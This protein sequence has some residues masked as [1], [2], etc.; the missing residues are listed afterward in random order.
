MTNELLLLIG[1]LALASGAAIAAVLILRPVLRNRLGAAHAYAAWLAVPATMAA[2]LLPPLAIA[3][4]QLAAVFIGLGGA[5][6][7]PAAGAAA[8]SGAR[9]QWL[10]LAWA[11]GTGLM[12]GHFFSSHWH[13]VRSLG[14][15]A[16][17][18][19]AWVAEHDGAGPLLLGLW[20]QRVVL[21]RD[22]AARFSVDE[23][24]LILAHERFHAA[25]GDPAANALLAVLQCCFWFNPLVHIAAPR[26]R[27][28]QE[29]A[30]DA[31]VMAAHPGTARAYASA[32]M[33]SQLDDVTLSASCHWQSHHPLKE[34]I[35]QLQHSPLAPSRRLAARLAI[36]LL[37]LAGAGAALIARAESAA[38]P[39]AAGAR[40]DIGMTLTALGTVSHPRLLVREGEIFRVSKGNDGEQWDGE[41]LLRAHPTGK[42]LIKSK[43]TL[44]GKPM[45]EQSMLMDEGTEASMRVS[46]DD[47]KAQFTLAM[48]AKPLP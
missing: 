17:N 33:K 21:P 5:A 25:R 11:A 37:V 10:L 20:R 32:M 40:Y 45:G 3:P 4:P 18:G 16:P 1:R 7:A 26:F 42:V 46:S 34:R 48:T 6:A 19:D 12:A 38:A 28:D 36:G 14:R 9:A 47:G 13:Y 30:C 29:L 24:A 43:V 41:F 22:F 35:M 2:V 31:A 27:L 23:Q 8:A 44:N 15:L 39:A